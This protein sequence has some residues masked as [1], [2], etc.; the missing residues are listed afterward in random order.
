MVKL[1][2]ALKM[3]AEEEAVLAAALILCQPTKTKRTG[4]PVF[5]K[6]YTM[7]KFFDSISQMI[8]EI[9]PDLAGATEK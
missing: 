7:V 8:S 9:D 3:D 2:A 6:E 5:P 4:K 1:T